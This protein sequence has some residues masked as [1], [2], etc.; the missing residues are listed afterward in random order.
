VTHLA[1]IA[2]F[3]DHHFSV[4]KREK[5]GRVTTEIDELTGE[6]R[7]R[8]IGRMLS[9]EIITSEALKQADQLIQA[10]SL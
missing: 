8:E 7:S 6:N 5:K 4:V 3:G 2:G 9:G 10:G 1:Q